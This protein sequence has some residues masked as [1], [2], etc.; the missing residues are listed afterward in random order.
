MIKRQENVKILS[1]RHLFHPSCLHQYIS[2]AG[3]ECPNCRAPF[4]EGEKVFD[5]IQEEGGGTHD[6][7]TRQ[8][9]GHT[10]SFMCPKNLPREKKEQWERFIKQDMERRLDERYEESVPNEGCLYVD[11]QGVVYTKP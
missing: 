11:S 10:Q 4:K 8:F 7:F 3:R 1:C 6:I 5:W 2:K 9:P